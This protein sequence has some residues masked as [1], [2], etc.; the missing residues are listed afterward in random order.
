MH[1]NNGRGFLRKFG[2][3]AGMAALGFAAIA[4]PLHF[5]LRKQLAGAPE[6]IHSQGWPIR[7][8]HVLFARYILRWIDVEGH[9]NLPEGSYVLAANHAYQSGVDGFILG[10]LLFTRA[11]CVPRIVITADNRSWV[12]R[13]ER[14]VLHYYG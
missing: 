1:P 13:I 14:W 10:H 3:S 7:L 9:E 5:Y 12:V 11:G 6:T 2:R 8:L 4:I